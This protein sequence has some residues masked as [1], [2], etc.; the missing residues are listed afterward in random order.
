MFISVDD[1]KCC[2]KIT[3][4]G[5]YGS[6]SIHKGFIAQ[7]K[8]KVSENPNYIPA[9]GFTE[10]YDDSNESDYNSFRGGDFLQSTQR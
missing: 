9:G 2:R 7:F 8:K 5:T 1:A 3:I 6:S 4:R 10:L